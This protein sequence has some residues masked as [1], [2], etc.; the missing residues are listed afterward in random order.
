MSYNLTSIYRLI[1]R[2]S[3]IVGLSGP[4][5]VYAGTTPVLSNTCWDKFN[6]CEKYIEERCH[7]MGKECPVSCGL[8]KGRTRGG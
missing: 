6:D 1:Y 3:W 4:I 5:F 8:C 7:K 2:P